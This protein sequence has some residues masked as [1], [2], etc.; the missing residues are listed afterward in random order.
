MR[1]P[2]L[3]I[4]LA[5]AMAVTDAAMVTLCLALAYLARFDTTLLPE[6]EEAHAWEHYLPLLPIQ[7]VVLVAVLAARGLYHIRRNASRVDELQQVASGVVMAAV[8][9]VGIVAFTERDFPYS[10]AVIALSWLLTIPAVWLARL[11]HFGLHGTLRRLG[12]DNERVL[13]VGSG[14]VAHAVLDKIRRSPI[15]GY[16]VIGF[17]TDWGSPRASQLEGVPSLGNIEHIDEV[18]HRHRITEIIIADPELTH[19][20]VLDTVRRVDTREVS[21]KVFPDVFQLIS[22]QVAISDLHGLPLLSIR[23]ASLRGWRY[24]IKRV[25]DLAVSGL[26]LVLLSPLLLFIALLIKL[27]SPAGPVFFIQERVGL[28]GRPFWVIKFR[29]MR[30]DAEHGSG[31]VWATRSDPRTTALGRWLRRFSVDE[32]PQ[33]VNVLLGDMSIVG[34]RPERPHFVQQFSQRIPNYWDRHR[35]KTGLT[36]WA[37]VNG[38][39]GDT[40]IEERTAYDLWYVENWNLWLDFKIM[41]RTIPALFR[42][43]N[44]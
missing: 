44:G 21:V 16:Q 2:T 13:L 29:S 10:R 4:L 17:V 23:D 11:F 40:S 15:W 30:M 3:T 25:V 12:I 39:R 7:A 14:E 34:P 31:P 9:T 6:P 36:G 35:E 43:P 5:L 18:V 19:Q 20:Q 28:D 33:F 42:N 37:Q 41:L 24:I 22:S 26:A 27:T 8:I 1:S 32:L 38:L